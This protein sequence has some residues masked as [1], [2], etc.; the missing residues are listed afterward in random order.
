MKRLLIL[1]VTVFVSLNLFSQTSLTK[2]ET[3]QLQQ[4]QDYSEY[5]KFCN[6]H[7]ITPKTEAAWIFDTSYLADYKLKQDIQNIKNSLNSSGTYLIKARKQILYGFG[8]QALGG[9]LLI[10]S[11]SATLS[12]GVANATTFGTGVMIASGGLALTGL[13][14]EISGIVNIGK[15]GI[16]LNE[17]GVGIRVNF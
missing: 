2:D 10:G 4:I 3:L 8:C 15:A 5:I 12:D 9:I 13:I 7:S 14:L 17:H 11:Y 6:K 1:F 16:S